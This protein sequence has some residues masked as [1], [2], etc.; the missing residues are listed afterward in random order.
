MNLLSFQKTAGIA[1]P[2]SSIRDV[3][4]FG[5]G[6]FNSA[7]KF[8]NFLNKSFLYTW[9]LL[10]LNDCLESP[11][12]PLSSFAFDIM[13]IDLSDIKYLDF[14]NIK[15]NFKTKIK[16][17]NSNSIVDF[18]SV[19][20]FK[21]EICRIAFN[22]FYDDEYQFKTNDYK[23]FV[24]FLDEE[25]EWIND[26]SLYKVLKAEFKYSEIQYWPEDL[27]NRNNNSIKAF[28][29]KYFKEI[30]FYEFI[31]W[32]L[33]NQWKK[34]KKYA[35][36]YNVYLMGDM[37]FYVS[38]DSCDVWCNQ[39]YYKINKDFSPKVYAGYPG[40]DLSINQIWKVAVYDWEKI[41]K[42]NLNIYINRV[43]HMSNLYHALRLDYFGGFYKY[44]EVSILKNEFTEHLGP[45]QEILDYIVKEI[46]DTLVCKIFAESLNL[47]KSKAELL[48]INSGIDGYTTFVNDYKLMLEN[49]VK[50]DHNAETST[51]DNA[52]LCLWWKSCSVDEK[53]LILDKLN[54]SHDENLDELNESWRW[55]IIEFIMCSE[56]NQVIFP[57]QDLL[58]T[59][60]RI[61]TPGTIDKNN[62]TFR[63]AKNIDE[64]TAYDELTN[65]IKNLIE[66]S[67]RNAFYND[68][69]VITVPPLN[70]K[71]KRIY[72]RDEKIVVWAMSEKEQLIE[73]HIIGENSQYA[74]NFRKIYL[75][76][77]KYL[78]K[79]TYSNNLEKGKYKFK[80]KYSDSNIYECMNIEII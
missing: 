25:Y 16:D 40:H 33:F 55:K 44:W 69:N 26:Y 17:L 7:Y 47:T 31:Q 74:S 76:D 11:F 57:L 22:K 67:K 6:D 28:K 21:E 15:T 51:H 80:I 45:G 68:F 36:Q 63:L 78:Y 56:F 1:L 39:E 66:K 2:L 61:N 29:E 4:D 10:P 58:G 73:G 72:Y 23:E 13:Y 42:D 43:R 53:K 70:E 46:N 64:L 71:V 30:L 5:I 54:I 27:K 14:E 49:K 18:F 38:I 8:I 59:T 3:D 48:R 79:F 35:E 32:I 34:L 19:R 12:S 75:S 20:K 65:K 60:D 62:W 52:P 77:D 41:K 9:K 50:K 24:D 37:P